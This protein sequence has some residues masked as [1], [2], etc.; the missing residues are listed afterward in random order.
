MLFLQ[1]DDCLKIFRM[2]KTKPVIGITGHFEKSDNKYYVD[3]RY[4]DAVKMGGGTPIILPIYGN[5][6]RLVRLID[7]LLVSGGGINPLTVSALKKKLLPSLEEQNPLRYGFEAFLIRRCRDKKIPIM[8][9]C[10]G[11]QMVAEVLGGEVSRENPDLIKQDIAHNQKAKDNTPTHDIKVIS[12][13]RL[14]RLLGLEKV[15]VNSLHRQKV[16]KLP[17]GFRLSAIADD[18]T[19][20]GME[21]EDRLVCCFQ[22]HPEIL[23]M[24]NDLFKNV[25]KDFNESC[26]RR[27][28]RFW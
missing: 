27:R 28:S 6:S 22:F 3:Q 7:G 15:R 25:F 12:G 9:V 1:A 19:I 8:G 11:H 24:K 20:E 21:S 5:A 16:I 2:G 23:L 10:R 4:V 18:G 26:E 14:R 17:E 13:S